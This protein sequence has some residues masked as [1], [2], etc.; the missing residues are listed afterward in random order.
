M[1]PCPGIFRHRS[2]DAFEYEPLQCGTVRFDASGDSGRRSAGGNQGKKGSTPVIVL[3]A[4]DTIDDKV[5]HLRSGADDYITKPF[6]VKE[7]LAR[8]AVQIRRTE[9]FAED[10]KISYQGMELDKN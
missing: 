10:V 4:K 5:E 9:G 7:V 8:I 1:I 2:Q 3:T 6:D